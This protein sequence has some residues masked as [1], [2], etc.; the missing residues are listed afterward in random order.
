MKAGDKR[1]TLAIFAER[2]WGFWRC[3]IDSFRHLSSYK[4]TLLV[5][6]IEGYVITCSRQSRTTLS[7]SWSTRGFL[8]V[9]HSCAADVSPYSGCHVLCVFTY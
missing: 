8:R 7:V 9:P 5:P 1:L 2:P 6:D 3:F 4:N